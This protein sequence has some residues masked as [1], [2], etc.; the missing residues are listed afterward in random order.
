MLSAW[1]PEIGK[2][3]GLALGV[4]FGIAREMLTSSVSGQV[5]EQL[6]EVFDSVTRKVGGE[7][8][9]SADLPIRPSDFAGHDGRGEEGQQTESHWQEGKGHGATEAAGRRW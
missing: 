7:P 3:K 6:K 5:G 4:L 8:I 9:A 1:E 2:L